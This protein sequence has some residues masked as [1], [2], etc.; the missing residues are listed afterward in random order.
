MDI[1]PRMTYM[2]E[3]DGGLR[4]HVVAYCVDFS[5]RKIYIIEMNL[6]EKYAHIQRSKA[7]FNENAHIPRALNVLYQNARKQGANCIRVQT[8]DDTEPAAMAHI[9]QYMNGV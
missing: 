7:E 3:F 1:K 6:V 5:L 9:E 4:P 8:P 2:I